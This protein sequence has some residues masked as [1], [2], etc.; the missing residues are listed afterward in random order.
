MARDRWN[1]AFDRGRAVFA[2]LGP[3]MAPFRGHA[4][5]PGLEDWNAALAS[6]EPPLTAGSGAPIRFVP[7]PP[8]RRSGPIDVASLYD[9]RIWTRGEV[10]SRLES[11]H[12]FFNMLVWASFPATKRAI[13]A[14]QR[15]A[16]QA[17]IEPGATRL[18]SSRTR[19]QDALAMLDEGGAIRAIAGSERRLF[20]IGHAIHEHLVTGT[21]EARALIVDVEVDD[22]SRAAVDAALAAHLDRGFAIPLD[23]PAVPVVDAL[24]ER[25]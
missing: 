11:W 3:A 10:Q 2:P 17:W 7:Q 20:V 5:W 19:E 8:K 15:A 16:L 22:L 9:E 14:R 13:N 21:H 4:E 12:D 24:F 25:A 6:R 18:P 1:P 23:R